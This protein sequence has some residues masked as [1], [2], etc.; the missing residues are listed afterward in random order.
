M[1]LDNVMN[2]RAFDIPGYD[3]STAIDLYPGMLP[4][5]FHLQVNANGFYRNWPGISDYSDQFQVWKPEHLQPRGDVA[6]EP[7]AT[8]PQLSG[9]AEG[10]THPKIKFLRHP[11]NPEYYCYNPDGSYAGFGTN[12]GLTARDPRR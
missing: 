4:E 6:Q 1:Y 10:S 3:A 9:A 8:K 12:N 11:N 7:G 2:H 5:D